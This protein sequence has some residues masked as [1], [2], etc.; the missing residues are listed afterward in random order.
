MRDPLDSFLKRL[1]SREKQIEQLQKRSEYWNVRGQ[2]QN[3]A[4]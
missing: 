1:D 4:S 3:S 2:M